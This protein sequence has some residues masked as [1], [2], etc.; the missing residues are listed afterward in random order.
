M[1]DRPQPPAQFDEG[2]FAA[3]SMKAAS[4]DEDA[5]LYSSR[6]SHDELKLLRLLARVRVAARVY[7]S[8]DTGTNAVRSVQHYD[9]ST[10]LAERVKRG[11]PPLSVAAASL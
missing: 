2:A 3:E 10:W 5:P 1:Q 6:S 4:I 7:S 11:L 9:G 8:S